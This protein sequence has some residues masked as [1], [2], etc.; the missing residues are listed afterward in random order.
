MGK[1]AG[2]GLA[3]AAPEAAAA[4]RAV[5]GGK[6][7]SPVPDPRVTAPGSKAAQQRQAIEDLKARRPAAP[8]HPMVPAAATPTSPPPASPGDGPSL[9]APS[10][11]ASVQTGSGFL[12]GV[13]VWA[14]GLSYLQGGGVSGVRKFLAAKFLNK[15]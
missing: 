15:T 9:S 12:L 8:G 3:A 11:P 2:V 7:R 14:V 5:G 6:G 13:F 1:V 4:R 10:V